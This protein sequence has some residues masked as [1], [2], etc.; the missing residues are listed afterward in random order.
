MRDRYLN[1]AISSR[2][3]SHPIQESTTSKSRRRNTGHAKN[4]R[5][6]SKSNQPIINTTGKEA[7]TANTSTFTFDVANLLP[8]ILDQ[9]LGEVENDRHSDLQSHPIRDDHLMITSAWS[10]SDESSGI[11]ESALV[12]RPKIAIRPFV[13]VC[14][15]WQP[16]AERRL[17]RSIAIGKTRSFTKDSP[18]PFLLAT[19][20]SSPRLA[21]LVRELRL[22]QYPGR[23]A[24]AQTPTHA[25]IISAC[26]Q[27]THLTLLGFEGDEMSSTLL[28]RSL[29]Q[30][31]SPR[32]IVVAQYPPPGPF[33]NGDGGLGLCSFSQFTLLMSHWQNIE[34]VVVLTKATVH[35]ISEPQRERKQNRR[36]SRNKEHGQAHRNTPDSSSRITNPLVFPS[37][38]S[39]VSSPQPLSLP[40]LRTLCFWKSPVSESSLSFIH[41][42]AP[43][44]TTFRCDLESTSTP[45]LRN[46]L[47]VWAPTLEVLFLTHTSQPLLKPDIEPAL[48]KL[49]NLHLLHTSSDLIPPQMLPH[50]PALA[51]LEYNFVSM[52][53]IQALAEVIPQL[54]NLQRFIHLG[55][56]MTFGDREIVE[57]MCNL[58]TACKA[59]GLTFIDYQDMYWEA[60]GGFLD[61][62][63]DGFDEMGPYEGLD[64]VD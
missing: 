27:L 34:H 41:A 55:N 21:S 48:S 37:P 10:A 1:L 18:A 54:L 59:R 8:E 20:K 30:L 33:Q 58:Q 17:Y 13:R 19:L 24:V 40:Q 15:S 39:N 53:H 36:R 35:K 6:Q 57:K 38:L 45:A 3:Q 9:I 28:Y 50:L 16:I 44:V 26:T 49:V 14:K 60:E 47:T 25:G 43:F 62:E 46:A 23:K 63:F 2:A 7:T 42:A 31:T 61:E 22:L 4:V 52:A 5:D 56:P 51:K 32:S 11:M 29:A 12:C 64:D